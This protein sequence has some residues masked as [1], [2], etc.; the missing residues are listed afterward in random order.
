VTDATGPAPEPASDPDAL[1]YDDAFAELQ[2]VVAA[3]EAGGA[4]LE[5]T[6]ALYERAVALQRR[7]EQLLAQAELRVRQLMAGPDGSLVAVDTRPD[8][9]AE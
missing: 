8:E 6:V 2:R 3:L 1:V 7:C 4:S 9:P 5:A